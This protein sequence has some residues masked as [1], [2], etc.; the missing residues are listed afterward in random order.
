MFTSNI[1]SGVRSQNTTDYSNSASSLNLYFKCDI[2]GTLINTLHDKRDDFNFPI[3][4]NYPFLESNILSSTTH[5]VY[6]SQ[7]IRYSK[8]RNTYQAFLHRSVLLTMNFL[9]QGC[10]ETRLKSTLRVFV[11]T[12]I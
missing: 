12:I 4:P 7:F 11:V 6:T 10:I 2:D 9:N 3:C 1:S 5:G 8:A